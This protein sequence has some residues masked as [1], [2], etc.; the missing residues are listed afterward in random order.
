M[1]KR[2][3]TIEKVDL[4]E[5]LS[6]NGTRVTTMQTVIER[7]KPHAGEMIIYGLLI[8]VPLAH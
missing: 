1:A 8:L 6:G 2:F 5:A 4:E 3:K 7:P